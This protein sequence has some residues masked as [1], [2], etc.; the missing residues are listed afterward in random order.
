MQMIFNTNSSCVF[1]NSSIGEFLIG[2][3]YIVKLVVANF[4]T[5]LYSESPAFSHVIIGRVRCIIIFKFVVIAFI[6]INKQNNLNVRHHR[7]TP[8][9]SIKKLL[10][11]PL[12]FATYEDR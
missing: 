1:Y 7:P 3:R 8:T 6:I 12:I 4:W 9:V 5:T 2:P 10:I 11:M